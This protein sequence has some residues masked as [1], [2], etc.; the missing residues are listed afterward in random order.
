MARITKT[1]KPKGKEIHFFADVDLY[2]RIKVALMKDKF[3]DPPHLNQFV[4]MC[5]EQG[6]AD[7]SK[8]KWTTPPAVKKADPKAK[9]YSIHFFTDM[10]LYRKIHVTLVVFPEPAKIKHFVTWCVERGIDAIYSKK[11]AA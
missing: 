8:G 3:E 2:K 9:R 7:V 5:V 1:E 6:V 4:K 11:A 10:E